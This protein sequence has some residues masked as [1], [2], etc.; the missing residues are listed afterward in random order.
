M[1][2]TSSALQYHSNEGAAADEPHG[3][4]FPPA[5]SPADEESTSEGDFSEAAAGVTISFASVSL[6]CRLR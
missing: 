5:L 4:I 1:R 2:T 3:R 6:F